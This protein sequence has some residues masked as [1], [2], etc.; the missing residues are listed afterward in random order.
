[1]YVELHASSA[2]SFLDGASLPER[3]AER[4]ATLGYDTLALI[5]RDGVYG[6]P[7]VH[8]AAT[9]FGVRPIVG[10]SVTVR[11]GGSGRSTASVSAVATTGPCCVANHASGAS[12]ARFRDFIGEARDFEQFHAGG[13][14][15]GAPT[16]AEA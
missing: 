1:M 11:T 6:A 10:A 15:R 5:D 13:R 2:F 9:Q 12:Q 8:H 7:R 14:E 16:G 3:L 4:A